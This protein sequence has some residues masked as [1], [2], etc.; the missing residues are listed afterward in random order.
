MAM[1]LLIGCDGN[2]GPKADPDKI[3]ATKRVPPKALPDDG[4]K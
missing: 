4:K 3:D 2:T 1:A